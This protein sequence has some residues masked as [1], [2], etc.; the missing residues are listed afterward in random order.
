[1]PRGDASARPSTRGSPPPSSRRATLLQQRPSEP[2]LVA[3]GEDHRA[4]PDVPAFMWMAQPGNGS[5][6][7][8]A[9]YC[10][11][12]YLLTMLHYLPIWSRVTRRMQSMILSYAPASNSKKLMLVWMRWCKRDCSTYITLMEGLMKTQKRHTHSM[13]D[14]RRKGRGAT[15]I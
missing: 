2:R 8:L 1:M 12:M 9:K 5:T 4:Y 10:I 7:T 6:D 3:E 14:C 13:V 15:G 11:L